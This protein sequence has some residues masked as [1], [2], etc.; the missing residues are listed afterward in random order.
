MSTNS[1]FNCSVAALP[2]TR[3][4]SSDREPQGVTMSRKTA[5]RIGL[6]GLK[7]DDGV[8]RGTG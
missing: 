8:D 4:A 7:A 6:R 5:D 3:D 1:T 2:E